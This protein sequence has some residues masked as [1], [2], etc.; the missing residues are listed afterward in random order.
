MNPIPFIDRDALTRALPMA[1]AIDTLEAAF[2]T[3]D[4]TAP[5]RS[6]VD[7]GGG[8]LLLMPAA[9]PAGVGV[10]LVTVTPG[11]PARGVDLI[12]GVYVLFDAETRAPRALIDGAAMTGLR[13]AAV[14][15]LAT[16]HLARTDATRLVV[17]GAGTQGRAHVTAMR[18]VRDI[19]RVTVVSRTRARAQTLVDD[20]SADGVEANVGTP[21]SVTAADIV[22]T[23]TTSASPVFDG[24][25]LPDGVH[26]NAVGAYQP[27]ARELDTTTV[28][29]GRLVV[30]DREAAT[31]EAGDL[32]IPIASGDLAPGDVAADLRQLVTGTTVRRTPDD[33]TVFKSVGLA[34]EDLAIAVAAVE[35]HGLGG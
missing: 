35:H 7:V 33:V 10:K 12:H 27:T 18:A 30:E 26:I 24:A 23:C 22:C 28:R 14:S 29:R 17:F 31:A 5:P 2:A 25:L 13:T 9:S 16:R 6:H 34:I 4:A 11:N 21:D 32:A 15:G 20:L 1:A 3:D 19:A 8:D